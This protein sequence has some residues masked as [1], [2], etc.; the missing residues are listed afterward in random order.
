MTNNTAQ[1]PAASIDRPLPAS[2]IAALA[3]SPA[4]DGVVAPPLSAAA[5]TGGPEHN[6]HFQ[7]L[8]NARQSKEERRA[9]YWLARAM[10][11]NPSWARA[12]R[13]F[14][15]SALARRLNLESHHLKLIFESE[16]IQD[17]V[18]DTFEPFDETPD[19]TVRYH[20][21]Y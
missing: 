19:I 12:M 7:P 20:K 14:T 11:K 15:I 17:T 21:S 18:E 6:H 2:G 16:P 3:S 8:V 5:T 10:G 4:E 9:K 13:D 1:S